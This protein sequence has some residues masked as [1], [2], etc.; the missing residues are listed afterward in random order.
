MQRRDNAAGQTRRIVG[1]VLCH[2]NN[3]RT[4]SVLVW[5]AA[6]MTQVLLAGVPRI[7]AKHCASA[8]PPKSKMPASAC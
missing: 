1:G 3:R 5:L 6:G 8:L 4:V 2:S 7:Q